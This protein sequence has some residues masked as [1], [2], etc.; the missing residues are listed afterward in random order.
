MEDYFVDYFS[1][2]EE[3]EVDEDDDDDDEEETRMARAVE[4]MP[5]AA[6]GQ[7]TRNS[8]RNNNE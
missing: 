1:S 5:S 6:S 7:V 4:G 8:R 3:D 2:E